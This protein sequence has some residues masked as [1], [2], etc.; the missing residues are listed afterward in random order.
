MNSAAKMSTFPEARAKGFGLLRLILIVPRLWALR[1]FVMLLAA[2]LLEGIGLAT[3]LPLLT[4]V[5]SGT[6]GFQANPGPIGAVLAWL[7]AVVGHDAGPGLLF[8]LI[9]A[10]FWLKGGAIIVARS[11]VA[12]LMARFVTD[13]RALLLDSMARARWSYFGTKPAGDLANAITVEVTRCGSV[14]SLCFDFVAAAMQVAVYLALAILVSWQLT[15]A[16]LV[17]SVALWT[18]L[19]RFVRMARSSGRMQSQSFQEVSRRLV[20]QLVGIKAIKAMGAEDRFTPL[21]M[22]ENENLYHGLRLNALSSTFL[23]GLAE[24]LLITMMA[25]IGIASIVWLKVEFAELAVMG[26]ALYRTATTAL[27][28][29]SQYQGLVSHE[30]FVQGAIEELHEADAAREVRGTGQAPSLHKQLAIRDLGFAYDDRTILDRVNLTIEAGMLTVLIG[31]SGSGKTTLLDLLIGLHRP[32]TGA[33]EVDGTSLADVDTLA[34]RQR[35]GYVPQDTLL[36]N[37]T[38]MANVTLGDP[39]LTEQDAI[40]ALRQA[41]AELFVAQLPQGLMTPLGE[42]AQRLSGGQRQRIALA[43]ALVRRPQLLIL[44]EPT[45]A[46]DPATE[47]ELCETLHTLARSTTIFAVSHQSA[48]ARAADRIYRI[49]EGHIYAD[50]AAETVPSQGAA[51]EPSPLAARTRQ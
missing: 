34:W 2:S 46:L 29:Q 51:T 8:G 44:D 4:L 5:S 13:L 1:I 42:R 35:L 28:L 21:L 31:P 24:P 14:L 23:Q 43:R 47:V 22:R 36:F 3:F 48:L 41:G 19:H 38:L 20:D 18:I 15:V 9:A 49:S 11:D 50:R 25:G 7:G 45:T 6:G 30:G 26:L 10:L 27:R 17:S 12:T 33:I 39:N 32:T 37:D 40:A 16:G